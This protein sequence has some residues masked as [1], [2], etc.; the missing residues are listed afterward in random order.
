MSDRLAAVHRRGQLSLLPL[1]QEG[2]LQS[3]E[4]FPVACAQS[5]RL[6]LAEA[7]IRLHGA[8]TSRSCAPIAPSARPSGPATTAIGPGTP[9]RRDH[10]DRVPR[11]NAAGPGRTAARGRRHHRRATHGR[12]AARASARRSAHRWRGVIR[13][14]TVGVQRG[15]RVRASPPARVVLAARP[16]R[17]PKVRPPPSADR[18]EAAGPD[19]TT[20]SRAVPRTIYTIVHGTYRVLPRSFWREDCHPWN[21]QRQQPRWV[22][23]PKRHGPGS[24]RPILRVEEWPSIAKTRRIATAC[25]RS[26]GR[27]RARLRRR[28]WPRSVS[29]KPRAGCV[30]FAHAATTLAMPTRVV[31]SRGIAIDSCVVT[32]RRRSSSNS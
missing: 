31:R 30:H 23:H 21:R 28:F 19:G 13:R 4:R 10:R 17:R 29:G 20:R 12:R 2:V 7:R 24:G 1:R 14:R 8:A 27:S 3:L 5:D 15:A 9:P 22:G 16:P 25:V 32:Q 6:V 18:R 26:A 11:D